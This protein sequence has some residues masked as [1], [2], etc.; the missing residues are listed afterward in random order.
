MLWSLTDLATTKHIICVKIVWNKVPTN[1]DI[2]EYLE[3]FACQIE[4]KMEF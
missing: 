2:Y 4:A 3:T 1:S